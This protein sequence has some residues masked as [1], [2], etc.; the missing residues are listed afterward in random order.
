[1][2]VESLP[3]TIELAY[4]DGSA[5]VRLVDQT[6]LP[7][8]LRYI[9]VA[10]AASMVEAIVSLT[11][12]GAPAIG[13][14]GA[15]A[16][17]LFAC[18]ECTAGSAAGLVDELRAIAP[19]IASAR[20]TA[21]SLPASVERMIGIA[22]AALLK[23]ASLEGM[24]RILVD[25]VKRMEASDERVNRAIGAYGAALLG[26]GSRILTHCNAGSLATA[27][28]GTALGIVY[29]A[30]D[31][32][33]I[34]R[35][36]VDETRPVGQGARLTAWELGQ[37]GVPATLICDSMA[38]YVMAT[39]GIDAVIVGADRICSNGDTVNK[40]GTY[41]LALIAKHH[42]I[43]FYVAAPASTI[44]WSLDVGSQVPIE[45]RDAAEVSACIP[46]G[47]DVFNPAFDMTPARLIDAIVTEHGAFKPG[48]LNL[49]HLK[50]TRGTEGDRS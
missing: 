10:T 4:K 25:E 12:R 45:E 17:A 41:G 43:P 3:R 32:G 19:R 14:A 2:G 49:L 27:F 6:A 48:E 35:V 44:D 47:V 21:I 1:M 20:P 5:L 46:A 28:Y 39:K 42:G 18:N 9:T 16:L 23:A 26:Q 36:Y 8:T 31:L 13:I 11:V 33:R 22:E 29:S 30:N 15:S 37:A 7:R 34:D 38:A 40:V 24:K 50:E